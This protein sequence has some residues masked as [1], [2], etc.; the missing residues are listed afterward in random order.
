MSTI[1]ENPAAASRVPD[2]SSD[3]EQRRSRPTAPVPDAAKGPEVPE[4]GYVL[5]ELADGIFWLGDGSY[6]TMFV[7]TDEGVIAVDAPPTLGN[8]IL[9]AIDRVTKKPVTHVVY[10][11]HHSDH[12]GAMSIYPE[13]ATRYAHS[14]TAQRLELLADAHRPP[15]TEV[16]DDT[17]DID[18][19]DHSLRAGVPRT[20]PQRGEQLHLR[21]E[22]TGADAGRRHLSRLGAVLQPRLVR[23]RARVHPVRTNRPSPTT[24]TTSSAGT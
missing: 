16:F 11:H 1:T 15:P 18:A 9:R 10:S 7:V 2:F 23:L 17:L 4:A 19:G 20:E 14:A 13:T 22:P 8:N 24:S 3:A 5:D 21:P 12:C 6:Q